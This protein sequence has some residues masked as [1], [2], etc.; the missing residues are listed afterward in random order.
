[1]T[2]KNAFTP[3]AIGDKV[4]FR[5]T[6]SVAEQAMFTGIS[7]N[8]GGLYVDRS[9]ATEA[10]LADMA[11]FELAAASL[12]TTG[13]SR[14]AGPAQRIASFSIDFARAIPVG[15]SVAGT[16]TLIAE[17]GDEQTYEL[18]LEAGGETVSKGKAVLV[19][20]NAG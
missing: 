20:A 18:S 4:T 1:M 5:K 6:M 11:V 14:L 12:L 16:A 13:L 10:G 2:V 15:T 19:P 17:N 7:G 3:P 8:L 9:K